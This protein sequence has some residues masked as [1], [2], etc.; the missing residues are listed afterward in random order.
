M[1]W[2]QVPVFSLMGRLIVEWNEWIMVIEQDFC[3]RVVGCLSNRKEC[4]VIKREEVFASF[5]GRPRCFLILRCERA[6]SV[7]AAG[8]SWSNCVTGGSTASYWDR[9][10]LHTTDRPGFRWCPWKLSGIF[11]RDHCNGTPSIASTT[12]AGT[13]K[14]YD[15]PWKSRAA[16]VPVLHENRGLQVW[17]YMQVPSP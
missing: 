16:R 7:P 10:C 5:I 2:G 12:I 15:I 9:L 4:H 1:D 11:A 3:R 14:R 17:Y 6:Y 13:A 8:A